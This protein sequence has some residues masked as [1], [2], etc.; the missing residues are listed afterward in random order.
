[1]ALTKDMIIEAL[2]LSNQVEKITQEEIALILGV[3]R[4]TIGDLLRGESHKAI[5]Q[6]LADNPVAAGET[7][8]PA[9]TRKKLRGK[10][11]VFTS[12]QN[13]THVHSDFLSSLENYCEVNEAELLVGTFHYNKKG[14][15]R[16]GE[17]GDWFDP[18]IRKYILDESCEVFKDLL[19]CGELNI[20]PT[21][22]NPLSGFHSYTQGSSGIVP[23]AKVQLESLPSPKNDPCRMLYTTGAVTQRN[24]VKMK[25]GLKANFHHVFGAVV[26]EVDEDGDW[27]VRQLICNS[28]TGVFQ[29]LGTVYT[30]TDYFQADIEAVNYGDIHAAKLD[31]AVAKCSWLSEDSILNVLRPKYQL[32]HDVY[33]QKVRNHHNIGDP[34]FRYSMFVNGTESVRDELE[35]TANLLDS[36]N[37]DFSQVVVVESN[38]DLALAKWLKEQDYKKDPVNAEIFL[39]LQLQ[40][41]KAIKCQDKDF[42]VFEYAMRMCN[43][44]NDSVKFLR[45]DESF[46]I[47][48]DIE[49]GGHGHNGN[50]GAKGSVRAF[51]MQGVRTNTGH[52]HSATITDGAYVAGVSGML[53]MGYNVGG[54][55]WSQSHILTY[56][57]GKRTIVTIK[58]GKWRA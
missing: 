18:K 57:N 5:L 2:R 1:M 47:C 51:Q 8:S 4:S 31:P 11:F 26:A 45:T 48:G 30:P 27:F 49:C 42:S 58:N 25:A 55:S 20:L 13:N 56:P 41:Y 9:K 46:R 33:D 24:Y 35:L 54:S 43:A 17:D 15:Q 37:K 39:M 36:L 44:G 12:A 3:G 23:H 32:I 38:H 52:S 50:N 29:D 34:Y 22:A 16:G 6:D 14:F 7:I 19:W 53:D 21:A 10:R 28:A 40:T